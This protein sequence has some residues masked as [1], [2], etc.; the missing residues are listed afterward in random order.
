MTKMKGKWALITGASRGI[1]YQIAIYMARSGCNLV[2]HSRSITHAEKIL[3]EVK[4][5]GVQAIAVQAELSD[6]NSVHRMLDEIEEAGINIDIIFNNAAIQV[7]YRRE[8]FKTPVE[9]FTQ[10]FMVNMIVPATICYRLIPKMVNRNFGRVINITSCIKDEPEQAGYS[11]SKAA[12]DKFTRD[13]GSK[14][15]GTNIMINLTIPCWCNTDLGGP[16]APNTVDSCFPGIVLG[17]F[18]DDKKSGRLIDAQEFSNMT[19]EEALKKLNSQ[20]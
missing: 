4:K 17:A 19:L 3:E 10:S 9:D 2:L 16:K 6:V 1:G 12:L 7:A 8:F 11:T 18:A 14:F 13:L 15:N 20:E 5:L